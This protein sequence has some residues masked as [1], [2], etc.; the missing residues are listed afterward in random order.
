MKIREIFW[1]SNYL[2]S[3]TFGVFVL[4]YVL[5]DFKAYQPVHQVEMQTSSVK[6]LSKCR[7]RL[8]TPYAAFML[9]CSLSSFLFC[10]LINCKMRC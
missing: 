2:G 10:C 9:V 8:Y 1:H 3:I 6:E 5:Q 7:L 4:Y